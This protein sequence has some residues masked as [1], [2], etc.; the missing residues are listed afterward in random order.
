MNT[1]SLPSSNTRAVPWNIVRPGV[2]I[3]LLFC[4][5]LIRAIPESHRHPANYL[6][7]SFFAGMCLVAALLAY[8]TSRT[9]APGQTARFVWLV[10]ALMPLSDGLAYLAYTAPAYMP[11]RA[12]SVLLI[13]ISTVFLS[14]S[15][16]VAV[17]AFL[18]MLRVYRRTGLE[19]DLRAQEYMTMVFI[20]VVEI[21]SIFFVRSGARASG[22]ADAA[23]LVLITAFPLVIALV[24]CSILGV[25]IWRYTTQM[26]GGLVAKAWRNVLLYGLG[27]LS[28][29][30]FHA[31]LAF[32]YSGSNN[33]GGDSATR[34]LLFTGVDLLLKGGAYLMFLGASFQ[35][36]A[37]TGAPDFSGDLGDFSSEELST[38]A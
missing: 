9:F 5:V 1:Q 28:Y 24:P 25:I 38:A 26:G 32:H 21:L 15:R 33:A 7:I 27:W 13:A 18:A 2:G 34:F 30:A 8:K 14:L 12:R 36:E 19:V 4:E 3:A 29:L 23:K 17:F 20:I 37:C 11:G 6:E 31:V 16:I 35:Y 22:G 10:I